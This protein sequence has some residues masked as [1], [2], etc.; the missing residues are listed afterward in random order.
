MRWPN[1]TW[2]DKARGDG[3][4]I[5][6]KARRATSRDRSQGS[7][8][9]K[10]SGTRAAALAEASESHRGCVPVI[11]IRPGVV[12]RPCRA[13]Y[14]GCLARRGGTSLS[15]FICNDDGFHV[16]AAQR[17]PG[18]RSKGLSEPGRRD[19]GRERWVRINPVENLAAVRRADELIMI[20]DERTTV[21]KV[22]G[23]K[24][25]ES[26]MC[27]PRENRGRSYERC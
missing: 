22:R 7:G 26:R 13:Q 27:N 10:D 5:L 15:F 18:P 11:S 23:G 6:P 25:V 1:S 12:R 2:R 19:G 21:E 16:H 20:G 4:P 17:R 8:E 24:K 14:A 9:P 3:K